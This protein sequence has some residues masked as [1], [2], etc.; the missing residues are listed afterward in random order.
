MLKPKAHA[1]ILVGF[2]Q[3]FNRGEEKVEPGR[4]SSAFV[5]PRTQKCSTLASFYL[6]QPS[7]VE[8]NTSPGPTF[9]IAVFQAVD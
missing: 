5:Y 3:R 9:Q 7:A 2:L 8:I 6:I 4:L 1:P